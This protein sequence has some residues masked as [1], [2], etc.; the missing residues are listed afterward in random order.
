M[1]SLIK[2]EV[3]QIQN[4]LVP[5][6]KS[7]EQI[8]GAYLFGSA[9]EACRPDSDIDVGL[10]MMPDHNISEKELD[11]IEARILKDLSPLATHHFDL[12]FL[13]RQNAFFSYKV[14]KYGKLIY[15]R[16]M[17]VVTD[18]TEFVSIKYRKEYP[19]YRQALET[20][21]LGGSK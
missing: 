18:F 6:L 9:L 5:I 17:D 19:R 8:A 10:I 11:L 21:A 20:I 16:D 4:K 15:V 7:H 3:S 1:S 14:I 2:V 13:N 12:V